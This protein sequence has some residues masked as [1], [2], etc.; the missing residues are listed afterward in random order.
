MD[1][2]GTHIFKNEISPELLASA[3]RFGLDIVG[4][5]VR[6]SSSRLC[7]GVE[8]GD[9]NGTQLFGVGTDRFIWLAYKP[10]GTNKVRLHSCNFGDEGLVE[11]E[12]GRVPP[13]QS[14]GIVDRWA[15]YPMGVDYV[16]GQEGLAMDQGY[17]GVLLGNIPGGGMSRS[18]SLSLNLIL[19]L[20]EVN[21][22][23]LENEFRIVELAQ[24]VENVYVGSPCGL[25]DQIMIY[26]AKEN[27]GTLYDPQ[28]KAINYVPLSDKVE[29]FCF[30]ILDT[31]TVR[32]GL[33]QSTY[34]VRRQECDDFTRLLQ[35]DG[36]AIEHLADVEDDETYG[37]IADRFRDSHGEMFSRFDYIFQAQQ[38][39]ESMLTAWREGNMA[40]VGRVFRE[41]GFGLRDDYKISGPELEVM[42]DIA[43]S[44]PG[45]L[46]E[47]MLG[48]GDKGASGAIVRAEAVEELKAAIDREYPVKCPDYADKYAVHVCRPV[49]GIGIIEEF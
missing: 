35:A 14:K 37:Q 46:G 32:P 36:F 27:M 41:D 19:T 1:L 43:R 4:G 44:V 13:P 17:D 34:K 25:L 2:S 18:A 11:F 21:E 26:Y 22:L 28:T 24:A 29:D 40:Q 15:R 10:N 42:C 31:G 23:S 39:F 8:H 47:R 20:L 48:G 7:L 33:E 16:L 49:G 3:K 9:Y 30:M 5:K 12:I 6:R 45:V 38:R